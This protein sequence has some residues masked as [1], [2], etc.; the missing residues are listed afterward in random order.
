MQGKLG[1]PLRQKKTLKIPTSQVGLKHP[2]LT[3]GIWIVCSTKN[4][5]LY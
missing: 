1:A 3:L 4:L 5:H 2:P